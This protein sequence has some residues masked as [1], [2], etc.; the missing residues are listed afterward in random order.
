[1][2]ENTCE[3]TGS[4]EPRAQTHMSCSRSDCANTLSRTVCLADLRHSWNKPQ[5]KGSGLCG[6]VTH[7]VKPPEPQCGFCLLYVY[8]HVYVSVYECVFD[9]QCGSL[10]EYASLCSHK[11]SLLSDVG[12]RTPACDSCGPQQWD[13]DYVGDR[14]WQ[15]QPET[16]QSLKHELTQ[17]QRIQHSRCRSGAVWR[18]YILNLLLISLIS[19]PVASNGSQI[20][21]TYMLMIDALCVAVPL[22]KQQLI[23]EHIQRFHE[24]KDEW[25]FSQM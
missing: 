12:W 4:D 22:K 19:G 8:I 5:Q 18:L 25:T 21:K 1:M 14:Q 23:Y 3:Q 17:D 6:T 16:K 7:H 11:Y 24:R 15:Q 9:F 13:Q 2:Q 10:F 20:V